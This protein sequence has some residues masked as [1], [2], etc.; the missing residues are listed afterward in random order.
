MKTEP[1]PAWRI[2]VNP[3]R[4]GHI[5]LDNPFL[6]SQNAVRLELGSG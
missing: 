2:R 3:F 5:Y 6:E 1:S 4:S